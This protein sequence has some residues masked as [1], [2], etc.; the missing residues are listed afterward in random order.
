MIIHGMDVMMVTVPGDGEEVV[1]DEG[2]EAVSLAA[3]LAV[4][5]AVHLEVLM[6]PELQPADGGIRSP[7]SSSGSSTI[8]WRYPATMRTLEALGANR[9]GSG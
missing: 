4:L 8:R 3:H 7:L 5:L 2:L 1:E 9:G 6:A